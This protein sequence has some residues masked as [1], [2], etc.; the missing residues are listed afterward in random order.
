M[1]SYALVRNMP[2]KYLIQ[3]TV[4]AETRRRLDALAHVMGH[5]RAGYLRHLVDMHVR[6]LRPKLLA[7]LIKTRTD[8]QER[9]TKP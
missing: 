8:S 1:R 9:R 2:K 4:S 3:T 5:R 6:A 7:T